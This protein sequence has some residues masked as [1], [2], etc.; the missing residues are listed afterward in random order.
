MSELTFGLIVHDQP[1]SSFSDEIERLNS[2]A[3][4]GIA[5]VDRWRLDSQE[6]EWPLLWDMSSEDLVR[7]GYLAPAPV[8]VPYEASPEE[9]SLRD[10]AIHV[11]REYATH[12]G[13]PFLLPSDSLPELHRRL[14]TLASDA[15]RQEDL[16]DLSERAWKLL[17]RMDDSLAADSR[18]AALDE[19]LRAT[20]TEGAR[21]VILAATLLDIE[22]ISD[23]LDSIG[24]AP[25][26]VISAASLTSDRLS[27]FAELGPN[28]LLVA[29]HV[30]CEYADA[31]PSD[32]VVIL[33]PL[34]SN[35]RALEN[36]FRFIKEPHRIKIF[37]MSEMNQLKAPAT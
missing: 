29:T 24:K 9:R 8:K 15:S 21:C 6:P 37:E 17:D 18:L 33:W 16:S 2:Q 13:V 20:T 31:W 4:R 14:L 11:L 35:R 23:H 36:L 26:A 10:S 25:R 30:A 7:D 12:R 1:P 19:I 22:Y 32:V 5:I 3:Q 28:E 27:A 34:R